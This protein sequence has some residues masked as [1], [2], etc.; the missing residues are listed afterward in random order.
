[1]K[2]LAQWAMQSRLRVTVLAFVCAALPVF[3]WLSAALVGLVVLRQGGR[4]GRAVLA[5]SVLPAIAWFSVGDPSPLIAILGVAGLAGVLRQ[6]MRL[7]KTLYLATVLGAGLYFLI[8][9]MMPKLLELVVDNTEQVFQQSFADKPQVWAQIEPLFA[10]LITGVFAALNSLAIMLSL[11]LARYWQS[12]FYNPGGFGQ[13][14]KALRLS[15]GYTVPVVLMLLGA[16]SLAPQLVGLIPVT[17]VIM[18]LAGLSLLH[19]LAAKKAGSF[20][21]MPVYVALFLFG[22]YTYT[23]LILL[24]CLDS[25]INLRGRVKDTA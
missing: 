11:L 10:P 12:E 17:T 4:D 25:F 21:M 8:P 24:A 7:D 18:M 1:M 23:L 3:F 2:A 9:E 22:P 14:F 19:A 16:A 13:E 6:T 5:W 15:A 20:W